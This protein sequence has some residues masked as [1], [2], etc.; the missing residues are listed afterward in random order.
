MSQPPDSDRV[1]IRLERWKRQLIDL[2]LRNKLL[3][4][5]PSKLGTVDVV[6]EL[7]QTAFVH[8]L[9]GGSFQFDP[10]P[11][12]EERESL[13]QPDSPSEPPVPP[14]F[15][16]PIEQESFSRPSSPTQPPAPGLDQPGGADLND[17]PVP[18]PR[19]D[20][21]R[22]QELTKALKFLF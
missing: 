20:F 18:Q 2:S 6:D 11:E 8:L 1:G 13:P 5:R 22:G 16:L 14:G 12:P 4:Y 17:D 19:R 21:T 15:A 9:S 3:N 7:P 10:R